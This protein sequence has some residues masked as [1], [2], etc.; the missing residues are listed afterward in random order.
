[1]LSAAERGHA[2]A[3]RVKGRLSIERRIRALLISVH[4][5][6]RHRARK[7]SDLR[8]S[9]VLIDSLTSALEVAASH[10]GRLTAGRQTPTAD[11]SPCSN[12]SR[13]T[14][15]DDFSGYGSGN[16]DGT[17]SIVLGFELTET[18]SECFAQEIE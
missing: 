7:G 18:T 4:R 14:G 12:V 1:M 9:A 5:Y 11:Q 17:R 8:W 6:A 15:Q 3:S 10:D 16:L 13:T 2:V